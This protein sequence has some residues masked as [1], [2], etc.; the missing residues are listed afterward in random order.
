[1]SAWTI[2]QLRELAPGYVMGT[3]T[4]DELALFTTALTD[5]DTAALLAIEIDAHRAAFEYLASAQP[6]TPPASLKARVASRIADE[7]A[8]PVGLETRTIPLADRRKSPVAMPAIAPTDADRRTG[9]RRAVHVTPQYSPVARARKSRGGWI[10]AGGFGLAMAASLFFAL[11]TR[12]QFDQLQAELHAQQS[13]SKQA[14][15]RL[16]YRDS[17]VDL[18]THSEGN[19]VVVSLQP[20]DGAA[21]SMQ[22]YFNKQTGESFVHA[23]GLAQVAK[24]RA[25]CLWIIRNGKPESVTLFKPD[26]DGHR[27]ING[28]TIPGGTQGVSA[29]AV[30]EEDAAGAAAPTMTPFLVGAVAP[31]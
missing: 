14:L 22:V 5:A 29:F 26:D 28:V 31:K 10:A 7:H 17:T 20:N 25:Y 30:T 4:K 12:A 23:S 13:I 6:V 11:N 1:M 19:I 2:D 24:N 9:D 3:L 8:G 18:L 27:L 15:G 21:R 16:A